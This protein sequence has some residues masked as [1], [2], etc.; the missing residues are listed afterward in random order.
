MEIFNSLK[1]IQSGLKPLKEWEQERKN[2]KLRREALYKVNPATPEEIER[3]KQLSM[4]VI[5]AV[6]IMDDYSESAAQKMEMATESLAGLIALPLSIIMVIGAFRSKKITH[7]FAWEIGGVL[8]S[9]AAGIPLIFW[10]TH[11]QKEASR[12]ARSKARKTELND[13][14]NFLV[15][16]PEQIAKQQAIAHSL[17]DD[18]KEKGKWKQLIPFHEVVKTLNDHKEDKKIYEEEIRTQAQQRETELALKR[19]NMNPAMLAQADKDRDLITRVIRDINLKSEEYS[20]NTET[21]FATVSMLSLIAGAGA[22][23]IAAGIT[24][25]AQKLFKVKKPIKGLEAI[26]G[27]TAGSI[28]P[29]IVPMIAQKYVMASA[30]IGRFKEKQEWLNNPEKLKYFEQEEMESVKHI[31]APKEKK[32]FFKSVND[33]FKFFFTLMKDGKEYDKYMKE[34][35]QMDKKHRK[36]ILQLDATEEQEKRAKSVQ[37]KVFN[38]FEISDEMW[39]RYSEDAEAGVQL[40]T[41]LVGAGLSL[42]MLAPAAV[43]IYLGGSEKGRAFLEKLITKFSK[44]LDNGKKGIISKIIDSKSVQ[45]IGRAYSKIPVIGKHPVI[46]ALA[47][48]GVALFGGIIWGTFALQSKLT[49]YQKNAGKIGFMEAMKTLKDPVHFVDMYATTPSEENGSIAQNPDKPQTKDVTKEESY[50]QPEVEAVEEPEIVNN[51]KPE[52]TKTAFIQDAPQT[53]VSTPQSNHSTV[54]KNPMI[55]KFVEMRRMQAA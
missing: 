5:N 30:K 11:K 17:P 32:G 43:G 4:S 34:N 10:A 9:F 2:E 25:V 7:A 14:R 8:A 36:A 49:E 21:A 31:E 18:P 45:A 48:L 26:I 40:G 37:E 24:H 50:K 12:V 38:V 51:S 54:V 42:L 52:P 29:I 39:Q 44:K 19:A 47:G 41:Q 27:I 3:N 28:I 15:L 22:G 55:S 53:A 13:W 23:G 6:D 46:T 1:K 35:G 20:E 16:T 33:N